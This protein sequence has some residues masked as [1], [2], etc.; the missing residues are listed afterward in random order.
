M[1]ENFGGSI[2]YL[3][4][5]LIQLL[6]LSFYSYLVILNPKKIIADY[7]VG[8]GAIAPIRL[9]GSFIVPL[10]LVGIYLLFTSI[11]GAWIYFVLGLLTSLYQLFYDLGTRFGII[12]K[13][14]TIINKTED[15]II[16]IVFVVAG[17]ILINGLYDKFYKVAQQLFNFKVSE[18]SKRICW[19]CITNNKYYDFVPHNHIKS[20]T[21]NAVYY[22]NIPKVNKKLSGPV[23][24]KVDNKWV[25]YQPEN[26]ELIFFPNYLIHDAT[27]HDSKEWRVS[28]NM[29]ILCKEDKDYIVHILDKNNKMY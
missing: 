10:V 25:Y 13:G 6:G 17:V 3:I 12:D 24:F 1:V 27:K 20:S 15:T 29:E 7:Q 28:I 23:K 5:F 2:L 4:L 14:Y 8:E 18:K 16:S 11:E 21:I 22:L 19:A 26:N 9:I